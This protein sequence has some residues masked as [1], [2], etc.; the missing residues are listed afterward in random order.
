MPGPAFPSPAASRILGTLA[1]ALGFILALASATLVVLSAILGKT[2]W[3]AHGIVS[4]AFALLCLVFPYTL[5]VT[6][7][8]TPAGVVPAL[9]TNPQKPVQPTLPAFLFLVFVV[10]GP[11]CLVF[12]IRA[13]QINLLGNPELFEYATMSGTFLSVLGFFLLRRAWSITPPLQ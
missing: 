2:T 9:F 5:L 11:L 8:T 10:S 4:C 12:A 3:N 1:S 6:I 7:I 13:A